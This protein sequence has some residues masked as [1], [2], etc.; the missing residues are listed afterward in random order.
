MNNILKYGFKNIPI[1]EYIKYLIVSLLSTLFDISKPLIMSSIINCIIYGNNFNILKFLIFIYTILYL[2]QAYINNLNKV[3]YTN[4]Q[5]T[6]YYNSNIEAIK[7]LYTISYKNLYDINMAALSES[8]NYDINIITIFCILLPKNLIMNVISIF[9]ILL[10]IT[11]NSWII[12]IL[13][14]LLISGYTL[15]YYIFKSKI[16]DSSFMAKENRSS[17][18]SGLYNILINS[19]SIKINGF[20]SNFIIDQDNLF[21][22]YKDSTI[23]QIHISN[24]FNFSTNTISI[25]AQ[26]II[27]LY[28]GNLVINNNMSLGI[29][30]ALTSYFSRLL[31]SIDFFLNLGPQIQDLK[32]SY[33]RLSKNLS[34]KNYVYKNKILSSID[35]ITISDVHFNYNSSSHFKFNYKFIKGNIYWIKGLNGSGKTTL[36]N[37]VSGLFEFDFK[38]NIY[39]DDFNFLDLD[40]NHFRKNNLCIVEQKPFILNT[41]ISKNILIK[42]KYNLNSPTYNNIVQSLNIDKIPSYTNEYDSPTIIDKSLSGGEKQKLVISRTLLSSSSIWIFDEPTSSLDSKSSKVFFELLDKYKRDKIIIIISHEEVPIYNK[43]IN[44]KT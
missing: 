14:I 12:S 9:F 15:L 27:L 5:L 17:F 43:I 30:I 39:I 4:I 35:S 3:I 21:Q 32:S 41:N 2:T 40:L 13:F 28:G 23:N 18:I 42:S 26:V 22:K 24:Y 34:Y 38:G 8:I 7:K 11:K 16:Y 25:I 20:L 6:A 44:L 36:I 19:K 1:N 29:F 37:L 10:I 31:D 33:N